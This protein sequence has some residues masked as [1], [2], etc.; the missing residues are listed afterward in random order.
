MELLIGRL[1]ESSETSVEL[2]R[3]KSRF[4]QDAVGNKA[5]YLVHHIAPFNPIVRYAAS[6]HFVLDPNT[7]KFKGDLS[8]ALNVITDDGVTW[9][10]LSHP[11]T[12]GKS[13]TSCYENRLL[14]ITSTTEDLRRKTDLEIL[15]TFTNLFVSKEDYKF[16][17][18]SDKAAI[19]EKLAYNVCEK[20]HEDTI[21]F[22]KSFPAG[23]RLVE[24]IEREIRNGMRSNG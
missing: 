18:E 2:Y 3:Y 10:V 19:E 17:P 13:A 5:L 22:L 23:K 9:A 8:Y 14:N 6:E 12:Y 16:L 4:D 11:T 24:R 20:P 7:V 1:K 15:S 21:K